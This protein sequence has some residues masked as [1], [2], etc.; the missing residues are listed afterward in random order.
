MNALQQLVAG[1]ACH[2]GVRGEA[3]ETAQWLLQEVAH[4]KVGQPNDPCT[5]ECLHAA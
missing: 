1:A 5:G 2:K 4:A 3:A